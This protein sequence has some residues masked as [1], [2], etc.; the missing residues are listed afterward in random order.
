MISLFK[1]VY[2]GA[3]F[4]VTETGLGSCGRD[5]QSYQEILFRQSFC[6]SQNLDEFF[7][8]SYNMVCGKNGHDRISIFICDHLCH[9]SDCHSGISAAGFC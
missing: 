4:Q 1:T 5:A 6:F 7:G 8:I 9:Q 3:L 2:F